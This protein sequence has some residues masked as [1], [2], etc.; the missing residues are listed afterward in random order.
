MEVSGLPQRSLGMDA[1]F[2]YTGS[3]VQ[4][5]SGMI[6][7]III[8]R[9]FN[10]SA[11]GAIALFIA[12]VGLFNI[13]FSLGLGTAAQHFTSYSI[14]IG[15][16]SSVPNLF[17]KIIIY[18]FFLSITGFLTILLMSPT[19]A[20]IFLHSA[21][22]AGLIRLL[23]IVLLGNVMFGILNG[24]ILGLQHFRLSAIINIVI[25]L[26]YYFG[27]ILMA[28]IIR[29]LNVIVIGWIIGIFLGVA[30][31]LTVILRILH[32]YKYSR[33]LPIRNDIIRY[34]LPIVLSSIMSYGAGYADRF[35]VAGLMGLSSL[36]V[37]N[38]ALLVASAIGF[39]TIPFN[40]I[41][42]PKFSEL[43][44]KGMKDSIANHVKA[45]SMLLSS[46]YVPAAMGIAAI[47]PII[48][49]F[50]GGSNYILGSAPLMIIM[51]FMA[52]FVPQSILVA[53]VA[54]VRRT[55]IFLYSS[56]AGFLANILISLTLIPRLDLIGAA[57]G[58][59]SVYVSTFGVLLYFSILEKV[60]AFDFSGFIKIWIA[61]SIMFFLVSG[62]EEM[63][64]HFLF[65][66]PL[67]I[68][69]GFFVYVFC[70]RLL[71]VFRRENKALV[72]SLFPEKYGRLRKVLTILILH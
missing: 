45:S 20:I 23:G 50:I 49:D 52:L 16:Y 67:Y 39:V 47:G 2:Q 3:G 60:V 29:D 4:F 18:G 71:K 1:L 69:V 48:I 9:M 8:A 55:R 72:L 24:T 61:S 26:V 25:W 41:L 68:V 21:Y 59:S 13:I 11:V 54:S 46:I 6:F 64:G 32:K 40:N 62:L 57:I 63:L 22:Y 31:E 44:G 43:F 17:H 65:L 37:Y 33:N 51:F 12:I 66:L 7:Y 56:S 14:G 34:S 36:G 70:A 5:I 19:I 38:F 28:L 35:I 27:S 15:D 53:A 58:Y 10:T 30:I 42:M